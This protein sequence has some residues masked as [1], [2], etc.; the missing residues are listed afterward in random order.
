[1][2]F[3]VSRRFIP[4]ASLRDVIINEGLRGWDVRYYLAAVKETPGSETSLEVAYQ[5]SFSVL[6][7]P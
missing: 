5:V 7:E 2:P 1:M 6:V 4:L 3:S